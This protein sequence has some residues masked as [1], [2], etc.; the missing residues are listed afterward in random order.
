MEY[1]Y[2]CDS[3]RVPPHAPLWKKVNGL[4]EDGPKG[5]TME[6][7]EDKQSLAAKFYELCLWRMQKE[8]E[9]LL[10]K[11]HAVQ[12]AIAI[13]ER[14]V[15]LG[16]VDACET[17]GGLFT[18][19]E[20]VPRDVARVCHYYELGAKRHGYR[21]LFYLGLL[22]AFGDLI[23]ANPRRAYRYFYKIANTSNPPMRHAAQN[24][25]TYLKRRYGK[26]SE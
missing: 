15:E 26:S 22:Y 1:S 20:D 11:E 12:E 23:P 21:C 18:D 24:L 5:R 9:R 16:D 13:Y 2:L 4:L 8:A 6:A 3:Q 17:L 19:G 10:Y 7:H 25:I 14:M